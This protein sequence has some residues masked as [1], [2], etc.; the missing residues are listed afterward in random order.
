MS[1]IVKVGAFDPGQTGAGAF[2]DVDVES[3]SILNLDIVDL[4]IGEEKVSGELRDCLDTLA[5]EELCAKEFSLEPLPHLIFVEHI[6]DQGYMGATATT[7]LLRDFGIMLGILQSLRLN[8]T[9]LAP[10]AWHHDLGVPKFTKEERD[11]LEHK[12]WICKQV[13]QMHPEAVLVPPGKR[14]PHKYGRA[15]AVAMIHSGVRR[16]FQYLLLNK[17]V[18]PRVQPKEKKA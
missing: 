3:E 5:F 9:L 8:H 10:Q 14:A 6:W 2:A 18:P 7:I 1:H 4:P 11:K 13:Q 17:P 12:K 15:D 16:F